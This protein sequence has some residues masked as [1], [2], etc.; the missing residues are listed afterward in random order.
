MKNLLTLFTFSIIIFVFTSCEKQKVVEQEQ[1]NIDKNIGAEHNKKLENFILVFNNQKNSMTNSEKMDYEIK[2][3][4]SEYNYDISPIVEE[5]KKCIIDDINSKSIYKNIDIEALLNNS[6]QEYSENFK[7]IMISF[8]QDVKTNNHDTTTLLNLANKYITNIYSSE[9][10]TTQE[11]EL[12][13]NSFD[14]YKSSVVFWDAYIANKEQ[15][16][17]GIDDDDAW[18]IP[19]SDW[20][21]GIIGCVGGPVGGVVGFFGSSVTMAIGLW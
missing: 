7:N 1:L 5:Y 9:L 16:K 11:K 12:L 8:Y 20:A 4:L 13:I 17:D 2:Y 6:L 21:G 15:Q 19:V 18:K 10:L 3:I 14:V